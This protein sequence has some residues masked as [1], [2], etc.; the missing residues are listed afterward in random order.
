M[1]KRIF[2]LAAVYIFMFIQTVVANGINLETV[3]P[4]SLDHENTGKTIG[5]STNPLFINIESHDFSDAQDVDVEIILPQGLLFNEDVNWQEIKTDTGI[6]INRK[7]ILPADYGQ[8]F[9]L[10]Y[11]RASES[12]AEGQHNITVHVRGKNW[13]KSNIINFT[14]EFGAKEIFGIKQQEIQ[15]DKS[16]FN[17]Y[18]QSITLPVDNLGNK[19]DRIQDN[20]IYIKDTALESFRNRMTGDG[21]TNWAAVFNHPATHMLLEM[22]NPQQDT[23]ILKFKAELIDKS[24]GET[25]VGLCTASQSDNETEHGWAGHEAFCQVLF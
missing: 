8:N 15:Y 11:L 22:R 23:R 6:I 1:L 12:L 20:T 21:A 19:D 18:I 5:N 14:H 16:K 10:I 17:W 13:Q 25:A 2:L 7:W 4:Y 9:D 3:Y 24:T